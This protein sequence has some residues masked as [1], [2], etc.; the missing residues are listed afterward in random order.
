MKRIFAVLLMV[1]V[2]I[3]ACGCN[4]SKTET[5]AQSK[6]QKSQL[7][8]LLIDAKWEGNDGQCVNV[9]TF[10]EDGGFANW[11]YCGSEIGEAESVKEY[12]FNSADNTVLLY[13]ENGNNFE[14]GKILYLDKTYLVI[15]LWS[16]ILCYENLNAYHSTVYKEAINEVNPEELTHPYLMI[17]GYKDGKLTVSDYNYDGDAKADFKTWELKASEN[18]IF[19]SVDVKD[20]NGKVTVEA[21]EL[22]EDD[23]QYVGEYYTIGYFDI[24][25]DG[26]VQSVVFYG[27]LI[28]QG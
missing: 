25:R 9:I 10:K 6:T 13:D 5:K 28:I 18:I 3:S 22:K 8:A 1:I 17:L 24:N 11:C 15:D 16:K 7:E 26:E 20:D 27:E 19:K 14:T 21:F 23:I 4:N 2:L 12:S